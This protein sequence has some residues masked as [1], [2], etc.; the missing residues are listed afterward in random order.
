MTSVVYIDNEGNISGLSDNIFDKLAALG[1]RAVQRVSNIEFNH[2][3]QVWE[4]TDLNGNIIGTHQLRSSLI[5]IEREYL[6]N[7]IEKSYE[8]NK[9]LLS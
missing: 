1:N 7:L 2:D 6:N 8:Q 9:H 3:L 5:Q 4:A